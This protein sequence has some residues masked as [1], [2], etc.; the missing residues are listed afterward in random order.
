M[1]FLPWKDDHWNSRN[2]HVIRY[3]KI[4]HFLGSVILTAICAKLFGPGYGSVLAFVCGIL[5]E[6]KDGYVP[7][8]GKHIEGF[9]W[10]DLIADAAG[11]VL[12]YG[13]LHLVIQLTQRRYLDLSFGYYALAFS[14]HCVS[15]VRQIRKF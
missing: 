7:Y 13:L 2:G 11:V 9:S 15:H 6:V 4:E 5:W 12:Y 14:W 1:K 10:K 8:D 3:D